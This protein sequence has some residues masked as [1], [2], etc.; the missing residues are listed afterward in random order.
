M[1][2]E[3]FDLI[4]GGF[5]ESVDSAEIDGIGLD[6]FGIKPMLADDLAQP[7]AD[8]VALL[9]CLPSSAPSPLVHVPLGGNVADLERRSGGPGN[10]TS[11][12]TM[13]VG[14]EA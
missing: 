9:L 3:A 4:A 6:Q 5:L 12:G 11:F 13:H 8:P 14:C 10:S 7:I 1:F 2:N